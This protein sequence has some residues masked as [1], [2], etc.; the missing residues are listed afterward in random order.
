M[1]G[2]SGIFSTAEQFD[3]WWGNIPLEHDVLPALW[4]LPLNEFSKLDITTSTSKKSSRARRHHK[5][6]VQKCEWSTVAEMSTIYD[7]LIVKLNLKFVYIGE[8]DGLLCLFAMHNRAGILESTSIPVTK[9]SAKLNQPF[10]CRP[11]L[12]HP[13]ES[14]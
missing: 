5:M 11:A 13:K 9:H 12:F 8:C 10:E 7:F 4:V 2:P 6:H 1:L 14:L 3:I